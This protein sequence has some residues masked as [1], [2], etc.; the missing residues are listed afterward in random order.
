MHSKMLPAVELEVPGKVWDICQAVFV[1]RL[2]VTKHAYAP[3][4][5]LGSSRAWFPPSGA[6][7]PCA[8]PIDSPAPQIALQMPPCIIKHCSEHQKSFADAQLSSE[9]QCASSMWRGV[10]LLTPGHCLP[11]QSAMQGKQT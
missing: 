11:I 7:G 9:Q 6:G 3:P 5:A 1:D 10:S 4:H 8:P 2:I